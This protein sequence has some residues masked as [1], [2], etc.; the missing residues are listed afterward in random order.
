MM[1]LLPGRPAPSPVETSDI[2][3]YTIKRTAEILDYS[4]RT[5]YRLIATGELETTGDRHMLR[6]LHTSIVAYQQRSRSQKEA[7]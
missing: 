3:Q 6:V 7:C 4:V 2:R 5:V 1:T